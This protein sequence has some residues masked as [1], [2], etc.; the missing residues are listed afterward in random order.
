MAV[1]LFKSRNE[2]NKK[3]CNDICKYCNNNK[4]RLLIHN[5]ELI[6]ICENCCC[7]EICSLYI[8]DTNIKKN[9]NFCMKKC[10]LQKGHEENHLCEIP[11][12]NHGFICV[13]LDFE[14]LGTFERSTEQ[15]IDLAM[16]GAAIGNSII[17]R[18][19]KTYDQFIQERMFNWSEGS[20]RKCKSF[21]RSS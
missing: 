9:Q 17:L 5:I 16:V 21:Y 20:K 3:K 15:D 8:E 11:S 2:N 4:C 7:D 6:C 14:G 13:S 10:A 12:Y 18:V 1:S 19:D